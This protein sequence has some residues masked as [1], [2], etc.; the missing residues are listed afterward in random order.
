M[1]KSSPPP[2]AP[3]LVHQSPAS[4]APAYSNA[5]TSFPD[6]QINLNQWSPFASGSRSETSST[7][8]LWSTKP[9]SLSL[10]RSYSSGPALSSPVGK[11]ENQTR[12]GMSPKCLSLPAMSPGS[13]TVSRYGTIPVP[14]PLLPTVP[15]SPGSSSPK[16]GRNLSTPPMKKRSLR[17]RKLGYPETNSAANTKEE[18]TSSDH[19]D[20]SKVGN[21]KEPNGSS[22]RSSLVFLLAL[23]VISAVT[24]IAMQLYQHEKAN[25]GIHCS[26]SALEEEL[27]QRL[28]GQHIAKRVVLEAMSGHLAGK[29]GSTPL[30]MSFYGPSGVGK[31]FL[32]RL[33][34]RF[35]SQSCGVRAHEFII[36]HHFPHPG[37]AWQ[38]RE[39]VRDWVRGNVSHSDRQHLFVFDE[40]ETVYPSLA[41]GLLSLLE[42]DTTNTMFI[43]IWSTEKLPM[44]RYLLQQISKGR[45][46]ESI[47]EEEIQ[48]LLRQLQQVDADSAEPSATDFAYSGSG[49]TVAATAATVKKPGNVPEGHAAVD[50]DTMETTPP[51]TNDYSLYAIDSVSVDSNRQGC[52]WS[53][54]VLGGKGPDLG[55]Y[56]IPFLPLEREHVVRCAEVEL[57]ANG[58]VITT[59]TV[60]RTVAEMQ[61]YPKERPVFSKYG[62]KR[63]SVRV[64]ISKEN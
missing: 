40:M 47:R 35:L 56:F 22:L 1:K 54:E 61:F 30:V 38:Y 64:D 63:L 53:G 4:M 8:S 49:K 37:E 9:D 58:G 17:H 55:R 33:L 36:P 24:V 27:N 59:E 15:D 28:I 5:L 48:D 10:K 18:Q 25:D 20:K 21:A 43:F 3:L 34:S 7:S 32:S 42:E 13:K 57:A 19:E 39:Q 12:Q 60:Q 50:H 44:G 45:S 51:S 26:N 16:P 11:R 2:T 52:I 14:R 46:R 62:C 31:T 23:V 41:E 29:H 6:R